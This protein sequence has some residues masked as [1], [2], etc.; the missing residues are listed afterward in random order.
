MKVRSSVKKMCEFCQIVKRRGRIYVICSGNPKHKQRQG[1][2]T[3]ASEGPSQPVSSE[4]SS[5][6][7]MIKP[8]QIARP[9]RICT[10]PQRHSLSMLYGW[11]VGLASILSIK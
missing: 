8:A 3:F 7:I 4:T 11:R 10:S 1:M 6:K 5:C 9:G 2:A